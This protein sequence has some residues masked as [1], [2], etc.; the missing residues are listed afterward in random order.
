MTQELR[1]MG[2]IIEEKEDGMVLFPSSLR[3]TTLSSHKDHRV[4]MALTVAALAAEGESTIEDT[5][6]IEKTYP[7]F[8]DDLASLG[9]LAAEK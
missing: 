2:A 9:F 7:H 1:K 5:E 3:G 4:A 6:C 8:A